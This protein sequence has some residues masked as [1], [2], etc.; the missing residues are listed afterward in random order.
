MM[1]FKVNRRFARS[2]ACGHTL[3]GLVGLLLLGGCHKGGEQ[4]SD[5]IGPNPFPDGVPG[6]K[7]T[8]VKHQL[9]GNYI[10]PVVAFQ[11]PPYVIGTVNDGNGQ[12]SVVDLTASGLG[13][14]FTPPRVPYG[15]AVADLHGS[16]LPDVISGVY[17]PTNVN[18]YAYLFQG[19]S[20]G[21]FSLD[22]AFGAQYTSPAGSTGFRGRTETVVV[23]DFNNDGA[24]DVF[25]PTYTYLDGVHD[26][27][28]QA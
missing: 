9:S 6:V 21:A 7:L 2:I 17:S 26:L 10:A 5:S 28:G 18:S 13:P 22:T 8:F 20:N 14:S 11:T 12:L 23:A 15:F 16:G 3:V 24:V 19:G 27:S 25:L 1:S 4:N